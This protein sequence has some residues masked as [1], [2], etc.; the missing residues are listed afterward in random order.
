MNSI[1]GGRAA[2]VRRDLIEQLAQE[3]ALVAPCPECGAA[4]H[5]KCGPVPTVHAARVEQRI[6]ELHEGR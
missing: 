6:S 1:H 2:D 3:S 4:H 5:E